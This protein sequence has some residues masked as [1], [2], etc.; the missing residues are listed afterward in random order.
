V[1]TGLTRRRAAGTV[2]VM[3]TATLGLV[4]A[5]TPADAATTATFVKGRGVLVVAG[6]TA[7]NQIVVSRDAGGNILVN[8][9]AVHLR[10]AQPTVASVRLIA[11]FGGAGNDTISMDE[12]SGPLPPADLFGGTDND[13]LTGGSGDDTLSGG[14]GDDILQGASGV[15]RLVAGDGNDLV[16]G[17]KGNDTALLGAGGDTFQWDPGD[18]SD[19]VEGQDG[20]D[21]MLF[22]G[23]DLDEKIDIRANGARI[24][25]VRDIGNVTMDFDGTE[26][27]A[28]PTKGGNDSVTV[29]NLAGT[30]ATQIDLDLGAGND[31]ADASAQTSG[32]V[33]LTAHGGDGNDT[34][35]GSPGNDHL[36]GDNGDDVLIGN[37][38]ADQ[39]DGGPGTNTV[40]P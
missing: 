30:A 32:T 3:A 4:A 39:L 8:G 36:F 28:V 7:D 5:A 38:G 27:V 10:G 34:L 29:G 17:D 25:L 31:I 2:A 6:D 11:V 19:V 20:T 12:A 1:K 35:I 24:R 14:S 37:G 16:D 18:G 9:G 40:T 21:T 33:T 22:L 15:D 23:A 26:R 13:T